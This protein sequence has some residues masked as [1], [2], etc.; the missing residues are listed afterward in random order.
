MSLFGLK[1]AYGDNLL[2][3]GR[4]HLEKRS[5]LLLLVLL[6][7]L[8]LGFRFLGF[9]LALLVKMTLNLWFACPLPCSC[10]YYYA[11]LW[12]NARTLCRLHEY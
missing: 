6:F 4:K 10:V 12:T 7:L 11:V 2:M 8:Y 9:E 3:D 5:P 1:L